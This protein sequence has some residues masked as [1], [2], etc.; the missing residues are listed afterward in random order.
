[1]GTQ[2]QRPRDANRRIGGDRTSVIIAAT[3]AQAALGCFLRV[4]AS[5][6]TACLDPCVHALAQELQ[7]QVAFLQDG[8]VKLADVEAG[9]EP[10]LS[11][12]AN[13][14]KGDLTE[15]VAEGLGRPGHVPINLPFGVGR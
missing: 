7:G 9:A 1:M 14:V 2:R 10:G 12:S 11:H 5:D 3:A 15:L 8:V 6:P 13:V 4:G